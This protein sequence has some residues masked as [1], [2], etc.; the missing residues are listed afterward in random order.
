MTVPPAPTEAMEMDTPKPLAKCR[1]ETGI[2]GHPGSLPCIGSMD[3]SHDVVRRASRG[4]M[5]WGGH[6]R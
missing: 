5:S 3:Q 1:A 6:W 2:L 4:R